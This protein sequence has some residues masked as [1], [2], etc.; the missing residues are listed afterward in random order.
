MPFEINVTHVERGT[1]KL[2]SVLRKPRVEA[3]LASRLRMWQRIENAAWEVAFALNIDSGFGIIL[4]RI[5]KIVGRGRN[6]L[7][8]AA[9]KI[10]LL[11]QI[12]INRSNGN[13]IDFSDVASLIGIDVSLFNIGH[14]NFLIE[15]SLPPAD[16]ETLSQI[17][18]NFAQ[19]PALG[20]NGGVAYGY[21][22]HVALTGWDLAAYDAADGLVHGVG[23]EFDTDGG[24]ASEIVTI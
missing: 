21:E 13:P 7:S 15:L 11:A 4:D 8:D 14:S 23:W 17:A 20:Q 19:M 22:A 10:G 24:N 2:L 6:G 5:G 12:R 1:D 9:Y 3:L 18:A 16:Q